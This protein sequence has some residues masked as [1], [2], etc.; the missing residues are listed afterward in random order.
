M[1]FAYLPW[2]TGDYLRDTRGLSMAGHG[3][4]LLLL[5]FCWDTK[6]PLPIDEEQIATIC[7]ARS[8]EERITMQRILAAFFVK[9]D[10]GHYNRRIQIEIERSENISRV[11]SDAGRK[12]YQAKA[13][14]LPSKSQASASN[15]TP[16]PTLS[17]PP[18]LGTVGENKQRGARTAES[19]TRLPANW[20]L[21]DDWQAWAVSIGCDPQRAVRISLDFRDYWLGKAGKDARKVDWRATWQ[22]WLRKEIE[23]A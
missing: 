2:Y 10:D 9:M 19:G 18:G 3:C 17:P 7:G 13:K 20:S 14:Q 15:P 8:Q 12:G 21:P 4:Y 22:K 5:A 1:S 16:T 6:G 23:N 11:R